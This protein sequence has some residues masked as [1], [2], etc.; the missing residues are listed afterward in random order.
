MDPVTVNLT[1]EGGEPERL[2]RRAR[3]A[4]PVLDDR[5]GAAARPDVRA[6]RRRRRAPSSSA[7]ASGR[8]AWAATPRPSAARSRSM[9]AARRSSVSCRGTF[10]FRVVEKDVF[11][12]TVFSPEVLANAGTSTGTLVAKLRA[13]VSLEAAQAEMRAIA[14]RSTRRRPNTITVLECVVPLRERSR[15]VSARTTATQLHAV[16]AAR[17]GGARAA[18]RVR[19]RREPD[20]R[21]RDGAA[22]G[23]RDPQGARR[24]ARPRAAAAPDGERACSRA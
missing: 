1:G 7:R 23:A 4:E 12:A 24:R 15:A 10:A 8:A 3:N 13:G 19:E 17:R 9:M 11:I 22:E 14:R 5:L 18:D 6:G 16:R 21:A 20:A 2:D